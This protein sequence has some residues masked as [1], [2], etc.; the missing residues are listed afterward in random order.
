MFHTDIMDGLGFCKATHTG[1]LDGG[2]AATTQFKRFTGV[3]RGA[4]RFIKT[5][6]HFSRGLK[7]TMVHD[8]IR[9]L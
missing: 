8:E 5:N 2:D 4:D 3:V 6:G 9:A 7:M 1:E